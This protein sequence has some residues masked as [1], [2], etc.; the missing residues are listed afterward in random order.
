MKRTATN[1]FIFNAVSIF[2]REANEWVWENAVPRKN[3]RALHIYEVR[4]LLSSL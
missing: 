2:S 1:I 4:R 3:N